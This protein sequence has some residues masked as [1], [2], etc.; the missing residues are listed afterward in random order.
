MFITSQLLKF[1]ERLIANN[2]G[3]AGFERPLIT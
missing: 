1:I 3:C 2:G